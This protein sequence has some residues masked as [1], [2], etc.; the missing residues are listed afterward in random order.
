MFSKINLCIAHAL[1]YPKQVVIRFVHSI[2]GPQDIL[3]AQAL[4][5]N[6]FGFA[7]ADCSGSEPFMLHCAC[8]NCIN[9]TVLMPNVGQI[10][11]D[12]Q[13]SRKLSQ[14]AFNLI[15]YGSRCMAVTALSFI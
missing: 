4:Q 7:H 14:S 8:S 13:S 10:C 1:L 2:A 11:N 15:E 12:I 6:I 5:E 3:V 9:L